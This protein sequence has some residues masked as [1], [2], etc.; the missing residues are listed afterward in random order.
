MFKLKLLSAGVIAVALLGPPTI[1]H[2]RHFASRHIADDAYASVAPKPWDLGGRP[3]TPA[4]RVGAFATAPWTN[5]TPCE[6]Y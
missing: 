1:A 3:C 6:P 4:P 5:E 2:E